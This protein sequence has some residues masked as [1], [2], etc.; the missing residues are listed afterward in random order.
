MANCSPATEGLIAQ[1]KE[2]TVKAKT[3][4]LAMFEAVPEDRLNWSPSPTAR[5]PLWLV[6]HCGAANHAFDTILRGEP[7]QLPQ[8]PKEQAAMIRAG[9][10]DVTTRAEAIRS[11]EDSTAAILQALDAVT[12]EQAQSVPDSPLGAI[13][14][15]F[16]MTVPSTH[17][18]Y[19]RCQLAYVQTI[20]GDVQDH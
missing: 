16:W 7:L 15:T 17:I 14:Y 19:H 20:W 10:Q 4:L 2:A 11:V 1:A 18:E 3:G 5:T 6:A 9:G 13:P 12:D 8:D